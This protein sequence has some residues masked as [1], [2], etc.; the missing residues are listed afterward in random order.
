MPV[1]PSP[2]TWAMANP[3]ARSSAT[4]PWYTLLMPGGTS[5]APSPSDS[6]DALRVARLFL[7]C[8]V[9]V[10][11]LALDSVHGSDAARF[12]ADLAAGGPD[13]AFWAARMGLP[14]AWV[15]S[16]VR[17]ALG[18]GIDPGLESPP[19]PCFR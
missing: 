19:P 14:E 16:G 11:R 9:E 1:D 6:L 3:K 2:E 5:P 17:A 12:D 10:G 7:C 4:I 15:R 13:L 8:A 18:R